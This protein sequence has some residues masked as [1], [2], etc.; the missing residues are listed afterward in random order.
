[1]SVVGRYTCNIYA[2]LIHFSLPRSLCLFGA[3]SLALALVNLSS[4][5]WRS[6]VRYDTTH[7]SKTHAARTSI[8]ATMLGRA[9]IQLMSRS[10]VPCLV[11]TRGR[12]RPMASTVTRGCT[13]HARLVLALSGQRYAGA[14]VMIS[15]CCVPGLCYLS[16]KQ[17]QT[18]RTGC[19]VTCGLDRLA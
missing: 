10:D 5:A 3:T 11:D 18:D 19:Y 6:P 4:K 15:C 7:P 8:I 1:M 2:A 13:P 9:S 16:R 14:L 17:D 12:T